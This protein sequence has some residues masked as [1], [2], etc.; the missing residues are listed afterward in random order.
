MEREFC[1]KCVKRK[2]KNVAF[3]KTHRNTYKVY[4]PPILRLVMEVG[5]QFFIEFSKYLIAESTSEYITY[6]FT[7]DGYNY[8]YIIC[9]CESDCITS[10][11]YVC[12]LICTDK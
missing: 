2:R 10:M 6:F 7:T 8:L 5:N 4:V 1:I 9:Y 3:E 11:Y 12:H